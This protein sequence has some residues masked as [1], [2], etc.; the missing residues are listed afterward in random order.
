VRD[1]NG[2]QIPQ[3][4]IELTE[5]PCRQGELQPLVELF[6]GEPTGPGGQLFNDPVTVL[7]GSAYSMTL[8]GPAPAPGRPRTISS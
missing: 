5:R 3:Q 4:R 7:V 2:R 6:E 8:R 1:G